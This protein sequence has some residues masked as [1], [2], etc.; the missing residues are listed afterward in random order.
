MFED[1][2]AQ[3]PAVFFKL[4]RFFM[5]GRVSAPSLW[6]AWCGSTNDRALVCPVIQY[7]ALLNHSHSGHRKNIRH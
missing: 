3:H 4:F 5:T 6:D 1:I 2:L 7:F